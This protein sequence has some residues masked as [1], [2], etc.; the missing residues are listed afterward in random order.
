[1]AEM[2]S[3]GRSVPVCGDRLRHFRQTQGL[4]QGELAYRAGYSERLVRKAEAGGTLS[5]NALADFAEALST[6][7]RPVSI[8]DLCVSP[9]SIAKQFVTAYDNHG[10]AMLDYC[11]HLLAKKFVFRCMGNPSSNLYGLWHG[12]EGMQRWLDA[13]F[14]IVTRPNYGCLQV[15]YLESGERVTA[16]YR[17]RFKAIDGSLHEMW[18]NL[19]FT[20][21]AGLIE[22]IDD[23]CDTYVANVLESRT[24]NAC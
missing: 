8:G 7:E 5:Y 3:R 22:C 18:V 19:H 20:I 9:L 1:M 15:S 2:L 12:R 17:D 11:G 14:S 6:E 16:R 13:F 23:E 10:V 24:A 4:T 21:R